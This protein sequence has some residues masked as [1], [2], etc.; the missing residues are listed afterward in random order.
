MKL[1]HQLINNNNGINLNRFYYN[2][3]KVKIAIKKVQ[4]IKVKHKRKK[5]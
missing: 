1:N 3:N 2:E 5:I 4:R